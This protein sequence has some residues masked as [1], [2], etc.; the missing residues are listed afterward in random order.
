MSAIGLLLVEHAVVERQHSL[1][2]CL[3]GRGGGRARGWGGAVGGDRL[4][5]KKN[6]DQIS[7]QWKGL[8]QVG[9]AAFF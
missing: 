5:V 4:R 1:L 7:E 8:G 9:E 3:L 6:N 2:K